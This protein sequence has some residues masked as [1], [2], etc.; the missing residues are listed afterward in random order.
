MVAIV[1][2]VVDGIVV[3]IVVIVVDGIV[4]AIIVIV[5]A[6]IVVANVVV[7]KN[8]TYCRLFPISYYF[9]HTTTVYIF[10][11]IISFQTLAV[12]S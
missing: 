6:G 3:A 1:G 12:I 2:I 11:H 8:A 7:R 4:I 5:V 9:Q 10:L